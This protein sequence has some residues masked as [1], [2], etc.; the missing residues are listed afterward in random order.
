[1]RRISE[2]SAHVALRRW[3]QIICGEIR[4]GYQHQL[5]SPDAPINAARSAA[6]N[7]NDYIFARL[8]NRLEGVEPV[9]DKRRN[10][11]FLKI[12]RRRPILLWVKEMSLGRQYSRVKTS[13]ED[14]TEHAE[15]LAVG[16]TELYPTA[17]I[18]AL[19][20]TPTRDG[21]TVARV[22][23]TPTCRRGAKPDWWIDLVML[24]V[25]GRPVADTKEFRVEVKRSSQQHNLA[26]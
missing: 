4:A 10:M 7:V 15:R 26:A 20:Y 24:P 21:R 19:G 25:V 6:N 13:I 14:R 3:Y 8:L 23:V 12:G 1:M 9:F 22:S 2:S 16:Q 17:Q 11:R 5:D 18:L